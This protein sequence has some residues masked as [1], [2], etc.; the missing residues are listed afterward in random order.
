M[1]TTTSILCGRRGIWFDLHFLWQTWHLV[2]STFPSCGRRGTCGAC[3]WFPFDAV[4]AVW[5]LVTLMPILC[6]RRGIWNSHILFQMHSKNLLTHNLLT[7][8]S[9]TRS[10][11]HH[12]LSLR[13]LPFES[14]P[15]F[16]N[17]L[18][19]VDMWGYP[20]L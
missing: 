19:D 7:Q 4:V 12:L 10:V 6:G 15:L 9:V 3:A 16:C 2:T 14:S 8:N 5:R 17:S 18:E 1:V 13:C 20:V 11:F